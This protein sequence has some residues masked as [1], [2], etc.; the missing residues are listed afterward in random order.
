MKTSAVL[1]LMFLLPGLVSSQSRDRV[2]QGVEWFG[3][4]SAVKIAPKLGLYFDGQFR[5]AEGAENMQ[6]QFRFA[7]DYHMNSKWMVSPVGYVH[8]WNYKYGKQPA[9]VVNNEHRVY[10]QLQYKHSIGK[11]FFTHRFRTEERFIQNYAVDPDGKF[12]NI[13]FRIRHRVWVNRPFGK[14]KIEPKT[15]YMAG[16][17]EWFMSWGDLVTYDNKID[18]YR[19]FVGPGY[20]FSKNVNLQAGPVYQY[21]IKKQGLEQENNIGLFVQLNYNFDL[22]KPAGK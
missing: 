7:L 8:I 10:Q 1:F 14:D 9:G 3:T 13:Q 18:Q 4:S 19:L 12:S 20:Q 17:V 22:V 2:S 11:F 5:F 16:M 21:L 6:H 15:W